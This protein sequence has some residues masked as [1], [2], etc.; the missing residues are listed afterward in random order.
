MQF[1]ILIIED[2][3]YMQKNIVEYLTSCNYNC[4]CANS[5]SV[6][7]QLFDKYFYH[8]IILDLGLPD[9]DGLTCLPFI[10]SIWD[11]T[12]VIIISARGKLDDRVDGLNLGADDYLIKPF[13]LSELNARINALLRCNKDNTNQVIQFEEITIDVTKNI[14]TVCGNQVD[15]SRKE[16]DLMLYFLESRNRVLTKENLFEHVW[17]EN[18]VFMGSS[19]FI[20]MH[21]TR[22][23][24]KISKYTNVKYIK[25]IHGFGYKLEVH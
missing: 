24:K 6:G 11:K 17:G 10:K 15:F 9:G 7:K 16:Y 22:L 12:G 8:I 3:I 2:D 19:D 25:T 18:S 5:I 14:I 23:R 1:K 13:H 21:I 20:Y 4:T